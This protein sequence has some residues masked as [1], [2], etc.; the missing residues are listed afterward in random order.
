MNIHKRTQLT[1]LQRKKIDLEQHRERVRVALPAEKYLVFR[2]TIDKI[3]SRGHKCDCSVHNGCSHVSLVYTES[4]SCR[5]YPGVLR[6]CCARWDGGFCRAFSGRGVGGMG[7]Y[8][9]DGP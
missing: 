6:S 4:G 9:K 5:L 1:P 3:P 7:L 2:P 8:D